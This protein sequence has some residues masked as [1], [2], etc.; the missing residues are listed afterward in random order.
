MSGY[1]IKSDK[2]SI[3]LM[4]DQ[5]ISQMIIL[6]K[7]N[8]CLFNVADPDFKNA[9]KK[10]KIW[11]R[12]AD[13]LNSYAAKKKNIDQLT[14]LITGKLVQAKFRNLKITYSTLKKKQIADKDSN[15]IS[16]IHY[17]EI[18]S[19]MTKIPVRTGLDSLLTT[20]IEQIEESEQAS[21]S[22]IIPE[23]LTSFSH[24]LSL[25]SPSLSHHE[26]SNETAE[27]MMNENETLNQSINQLTKRSSKK[28]KHEEDY[29]EL[30]R[31]KLDKEKEEKI[32]CDQLLLTFGKYVSLSLN[33]LPKESQNQARHLISNL[34]FRMESDPMNIGSISII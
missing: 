23:I 24:E 5:L 11:N 19:L 25:P 8:P 27:T 1:K 3:H 12:I 28:R 31:L 13:E 2:A 7:N 22:L 6:M 18:E 4:D 33:R 9:T 21:S 32:P 14:D 16:W 34:I 15:V 10:M 17:D 20:T 30:I 26:I 29:H